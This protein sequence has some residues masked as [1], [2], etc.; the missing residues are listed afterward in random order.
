MPPLVTK[1]ETDAPSE[2]NQP[3]MLPTPCPCCGGLVI[4]IEVFARGCEPTRDQDRHLMMPLVSPMPGRSVRPCRWFPAR[5]GGSRSM[6]AF[7]DPGSGPIGVN[8]R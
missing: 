8:L 1:P 3:R 7:H 5:N 4:I 6:V 2:P